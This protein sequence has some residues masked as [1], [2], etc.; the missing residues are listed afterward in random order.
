M[1]GGFPSLKWTW[2][3]R[4]VEKV[5]PRKFSLLV[6]V[7]GAVADFK[8]EAQTKFQCISC[9]IHLQIRKSIFCIFHFLEWT[10]SASAHYTAWSTCQPIAINLLFQ[11]RTSKDVRGYWVV[12][13][14]SLHKV[15]RFASSCTSCIICVEVKTWVY[16]SYFNWIELC[17]FFPTLLGRS[18][19]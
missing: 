5:P 7:L 12:P 15:L 3:E 10:S 4:A 14:A 17:E 8:R 11:K 16:S 18:G 19:L 9:W 6:T 13:L 2:Q 1:V